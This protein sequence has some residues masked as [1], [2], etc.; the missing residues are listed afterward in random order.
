MQ[1]IIII[2]NKKLNITVTKHYQKWKIK[3]LTLLILSEM[4]VEYDL[5][6]S[7]PNTD[8]VEVTFYNWPCLKWPQ[9]TDLVWSDLWTLTLS[10]VTLNYRICLMWPPS[11]LTLSDVTSNT[12]I[13]WGDPWT[14]TLSN[15]N[16][17]TDLVWCASL[18]WPCLSW[19]LTPTLSGVTLDY[20]PCLMWCLTLTLSVSTPNTDLVWCNP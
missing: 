9:I 3:T 8:L 15:V 6:F 20:W 5:D 11:L 16:L 1:L 18:H 4:T 14:L 10:E 13:V 19:P 17:N 2:N 7:D 12:E